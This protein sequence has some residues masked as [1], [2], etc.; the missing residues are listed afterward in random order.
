MIVFPFKE[1]QVSIRLARLVLAICDTRGHFRLKSNP[2]HVDRQT[3]E[4]VTRGSF[5]PK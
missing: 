3:D 4:L 1:G 5:C 2:A